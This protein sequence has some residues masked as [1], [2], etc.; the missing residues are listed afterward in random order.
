MPDEGAAPEKGRA[1][2]ARAEAADRD[3]LPTTGASSRRRRQQIVDAGVDLLL[4]ADLDD[5]QMLDVAAEGGVAI[6]TVYRYFPSKEQL[7]A[8]VVHE[9]IQRFAH[10]HPV[11][12]QPSATNAQRMHEL[13][14][15]IFGAFEESPHVARAIYILQGSSDPVVRA[16]WQDVSSTAAE[17]Y[18]SALVGVDARTSDMIVQLVAAAFWSQLR[19]WTF[20][21]KT[22]E[23]AYTGLADAVAVVFDFSDATGWTMPGQV[24]TAAPAARRR[25]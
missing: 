1:M 22:V 13:L 14:L 24:E 16:L 19:Q 11:P 4:A 7:F 18:A 25:R 17:V 8:H 3:G 15:A 9:W 5:I 20:G 12:P 23:Q 6:S 10:Q 2:S 21:R